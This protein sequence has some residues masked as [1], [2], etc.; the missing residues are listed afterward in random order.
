MSSELVLDNSKELFELDK[1]IISF[2]LSKENL[3]E[4]EPIKSSITSENEIKVTNLTKDYLAFRTK[5]TK[6][7]YYNVSPVY[8]IIPP[9]MLQD[10]KIAFILKEGEVPKLHGHKFKFEG[11]KIQENEKDKNPKDLFNEYAQKGEPIVGYSQKTFVQFFDSNEN[12]I[13]NSPNIKFN[14][15]ENLLKVPDLHIRSESDISDYN[16]IEDKN[17]NENENEKK[18][19][20][21]EQIQSKEEKQTLISDIISGGKI[22]NI[23]EE[24]NVEKVEEK[25]LINEENNIINNNNIIEKEQDSCLNKIKNVTKDENMEKKGLLNENNFEKNMIKNRGNNIYDK[26]GSNA[27]DTLIIISLFILML[28]GYYLVK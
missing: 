15:K 24:K 18:G 20:L 27:S 9:N 1:E 12:E 16:D 19:L 8:C 13:N 14:K 6:R 10:I 4:Q 22:E 28:I 26:N 17:E 23:N 2:K 25:K 5:T 21:I 11:F 7:L 3:S